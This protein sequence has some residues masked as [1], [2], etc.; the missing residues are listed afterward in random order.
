MAKK[1]RKS[2]KQAVEDEET[3]A[4]SNAKALLKDD[5]ISGRLNG[6]MP[7]QIHQSRPEFLAYGL[8]Q[9]RSNYYT[10]RDAVA[11][12]FNRMAKD[13]M[14]FGMDMSLM[15][16]LRANNP[17][18]KI[19]WHRSPAKKLLEIDIAT[20]IH[21][22]IDPETGKKRKPL[23]IYKSREEYQDHD[24]KVFRNHIYQEIKRLEKRESNLRFE[25]KKYRVRTIIAV[26]DAIDLVQ[27]GEMKE[28]EEAV[29]RM[30]EKQ[31]EEADNEQQQE[32]ADNEQQQEKDDRSA[33]SVATGG[34]STASK[35]SSILA[36]KRAAA[37]KKRATAVP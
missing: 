2:K 1:G 25:K 9:F 26:E 8:S 16:Q 30:V 31:Q 13:C 28:S 6:M 10:L 37:S 17:Q 18:E 24:L 19:P 12:N 27:R 32:E 22:Q 21:L 4:K 5:I 36:R 15:K 29:K 3:W 34:S 20:G 7:Q 14:Y 35:S 11:K 33:I 23:S